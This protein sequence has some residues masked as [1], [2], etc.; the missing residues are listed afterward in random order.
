MS[1]IEKIVEEAR[2]KVKNPFLLCSI[3]S[4]RAIQLWKGAKPRID[5]DTRNYVTIAFE[6]L[7]EEKVIPE[8]EEMQNWKIVEPEEEEIEEEED[9]AEEEEA[10][11]EEEE[12]DEEED[13]DEESGEEKE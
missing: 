13:E 6:E 12:E 7:A 4:Q 8:D 2:R 1:K 9:E 10:E 3:V 11:E 5:S